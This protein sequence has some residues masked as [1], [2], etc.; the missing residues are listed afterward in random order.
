[1][2]AALLPT[3]VGRR[4]RHEVLAFIVSNPL[5]CPGCLCSITEQKQL[6]NKPNCSESFLRSKEVGC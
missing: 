3:Q 6:C 2:D 1:M 5:I 4:P